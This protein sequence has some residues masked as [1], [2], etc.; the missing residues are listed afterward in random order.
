ML[1][2]SLCLACSKNQ[3]EQESG[4]SAETST[5]KQEAQK[6]PESA[7]EVAAAQPVS[8]RVYFVSPADQ[9]EVKNPVKLVFGVDGMSVRPVG[10]GAID[11]TSGHHHLIID[12]DQIPAGQVVP[13]EEGKYIHYGKGQTSTEVT[14]PAG[15]HTLSL[16]F[17][18]GA[19]KSYGPEMSATIKVKVTE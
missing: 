14:L 5:A 2:L 4:E 12:A 15:E 1:S 11:T 6:S 3:A 18:D 9:A 7:E 19:H 13:M 8:K 10:E 16:Q 17:A